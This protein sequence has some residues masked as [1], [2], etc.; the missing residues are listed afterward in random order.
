MSFIDYK[1]I[2]ATTDKRIVKSRRSIFENLVKLLEVKQLE[3]ITVTEL[4]NTAMLNRKTF[5]MQY[6]SVRD[7][8]VSLEEHIIDAYLQKLQAI[9]VLNDSGLKPRELIL[10]TEQFRA[11]NKET[12]EA[13]YQYIRNGDF[14]K[15]LGRAIGNLGNQFIYE[16]GEVRNAAAYTSALVFALSGLIVFYFDWIDLGKKMSITELALLAETL[17][18]IPLKDLMTIQKQIVDYSYD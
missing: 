9:G 1:A 3:S 10:V 17:I 11:E 7:A 13:V 12:F 16:N 2:A 4:C 5:Y 15:L 14:L 6:S 18:T 8:F